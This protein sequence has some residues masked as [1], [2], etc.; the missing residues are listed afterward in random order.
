[1]GTQCACSYATPSYAIH[2]LLQ[3]LLL[4]TAILT[5]LKRFIDDMLGVWTEKE[6]KEWASFKNALNGFGKL[7]WI[8]S[9]RTK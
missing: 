2:E 3:V 6:E 7:K 8:T 9:E 1:M 5:F 4:F